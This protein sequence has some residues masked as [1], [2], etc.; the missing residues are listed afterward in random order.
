MV[1][2]SSIARQDITGLV[3][4]GGR[5]SRMGGVNKG[6]QPYHGQ[7]L[8][9]HALRRLE[10]Q[11]G[12][13]MLNANRDL[14][15]YGRFGAPVWPDE[16]TDHPGP[17]AGVLSG[18]AHATT[19]WVASVPCDTPLFPTDLVPRLTA[20]LEAEGADLAM[21][22]CIEDGELQKQPV[23]CLLP[24]RLHESLAAFL[25]SGERKVDRWTAL[26]RVAVVVFDD[27]T[28]FANAN[29]AAEL[30]RLQRES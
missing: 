3:L 14:E 21:A 18:L 28:A 25:Q 11:V 13:L 2:M 27:A 17:L 20:A 5:G 8:A 19:P 30:D 6:L 16:S 10:P 1:A 4:A 15:A 9:L 12:A 7:P 22:A 23:F 24:T 29:T 26:H